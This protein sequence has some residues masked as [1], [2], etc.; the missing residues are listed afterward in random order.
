MSQIG[1][2]AKLYNVI[3]VCCSIHCW[4]EVVLCGKVFTMLTNMVTLLVISGSFVMTLPLLSA[5]ISTVSLVISSIVFVTFAWHCV[6]LNCPLITLTSKSNHFSESQIFRQFYVQNW[7]P[8][9]SY[10]FV[11]CSDSNVILCD[12]LRKMSPLCLIFN[13]VMLT[14]L[15][16]LP[17][18]SVLFYHKYRDR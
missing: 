11:C 1:Q 16:S 4:R 7:H 14:T 2:L 17:Q 12:L 18:C 6:S 10:R 9:D 8:L 13:L 15:L 5:L 3:C